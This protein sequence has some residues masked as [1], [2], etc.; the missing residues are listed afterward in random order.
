[1]ILLQQQ[2]QQQQLL[3]WTLVHMSNFT[4]TVNYVALGESRQTPFEKCLIL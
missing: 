4:N 3:L 1:M 2:Q